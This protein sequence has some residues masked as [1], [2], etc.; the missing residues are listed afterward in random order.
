VRHKKRGLLAIAAIALL[1][2]LLD[3][4]L[5]F[6]WVKVQLNKSEFRER[7]FVFRELKKSPTFLRTD[8]LHAFGT[9]D[10]NEEIFGPWRDYGQQSSFDVKPGGREWWVQYNAS[11]ASAKIY[12]KSFR[13][14]S[15][16]EF[17]AIS[18][19]LLWH[20]L[21]VSLPSASVLAVALIYYRR[22]NKGKSQ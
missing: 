19:N 2:L 21:V 12:G 7:A 13:L 9:V 5:V 22:A 8:R 6:Y 18:F 4:P 3:I 1:A 10:G 17:D 14:L 15:Q 11:A 16:S 20:L